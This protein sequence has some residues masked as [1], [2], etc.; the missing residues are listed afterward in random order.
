MKD[1]SGTLGIAEAMET[2]EP[3]EAQAAQGAANVQGTRPNERIRLRS[4]NSNPL[5]GIGAAAP[6]DYTAGIKIVNYADSYTQAAGKF[7]SKFVAGPEKPTYADLMLAISSSLDNMRETL[8]SCQ[9]SQSQGMK[10][11]AKIQEAIQLDKQKVQE[12]QQ[13]KQLEEQRKATE[14][15]HKAG[16][17]IQVLEVAT[18]LFFPGI[19]I[20]LGPTLLTLAAT[21]QIITPLQGLNQDVAKMTLWYI[22]T[23]TG[24]AVNQ[25]AQ[26]LRLGQLTLNPL[27]AM[28]VVGKQDAA[29][30]DMVCQMVYM[31]AEMALSIIACQPE[32]VAALVSKMAANVAEI[33]GK[34]AMEVGAKA[35]TEAT[36]KV[37]AREAGAVVGREVAQ[38]I[39]QNGGKEIGEEAM[40]EIVE[41]AV[42]AG[43]RVS[44]NALKEAANA[45]QE[46][47][48]ALLKSAK[49]PAAKAVTKVAMDV[50]RQTMDS[51]VVAEQAA[52]AAAA[53]VKAG[54][55]LAAAQAAAETSLEGVKGLSKAGAKSMGKAIAEAAM[56]QGEAA[57][58]Q[59]IQAAARSVAETTV[60]EVTQVTDK[61]LQRALEAALKAGVNIGK[62]EVRSALMRAS[63]SAAEKADQAFQTGGKA[64]AK[65]AA[66]EAAR[67]SL[68]GVKGISEA[69]AEEIAEE[70]AEE[71]AEGLGEMAETVTATAARQTSLIAQKIE[72]S[73]VEIQQQAVQAAEKAQTTTQ[74]AVRTT[75]QQTK[76]VITEAMRTQ[77]KEQ[78]KESMRQSME[79]V[80][81][82]D[83]Q[84]FA[85]PAEREAAKQAVRQAAEK[86]LE[87]AA[88][89]AMK[90]VEEAESVTVSRTAAETVKETLAQGMK[91]A[92]RGADKIK[93]IILR[94][95]DD[96]DKIVAAFKKE[97]MKEAAN[98]ALKTTIR[99]GSRSFTL[100][101]SMIDLGKNALEG[102]VQGAGNLV[103]AFRNADN[104]KKALEMAMLQ[105]EYVQLGTSDKIMQQGT[106]TLLEGIEEIA[107]WIEQI[108]RQESSYWQKSAIH[109]IAA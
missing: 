64:A 5:E 4:F 97:A 89:S 9:I 102:C 70:V 77:I 107:K 41:Q 72:N 45:A 65:A 18:A 37:V 88:E 93:N 34:E 99:V 83:F 12:I 11:L 2:D 78:I 13:A 27:V 90:N 16:M 31:V 103:M 30:C 22:D 48:M 49:T 81:S 100:D 55:K 69:Q 104:A 80:L 71:A 25:V 74:S 101:S 14:N 68:Q 75:T 84:Q 109:F 52:D 33:A 44:Q 19:N 26:M 61:I 108:N 73:S 105:A 29:T 39:I 23:M 91:A 47:T 58:A 53:V 43:A 63:E 66:K 86:F 10:T 95:G 6:R 82:Q 28:H 59:V 92:S 7:A 1:D 8:F 36:A 96:T 57:P 20:F 3:E 24:G 60:K 76:Q 98:N 51:F 85:K 106:K 40:K 15:A 17:V 38:A 56:A 79:K 94:Q 35:A 67:A 32:M 54:G 42:K 87:E 50:G 62:G 46:S 21:A